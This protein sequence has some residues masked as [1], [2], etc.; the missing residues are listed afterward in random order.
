MVATTFNHELS[1][2][3]RERQT[4]AFALRVSWKTF[5]RWA[6]KAFPFTFHFNVL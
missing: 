3:V 6:K 2:L 4:F 5:G 1:E